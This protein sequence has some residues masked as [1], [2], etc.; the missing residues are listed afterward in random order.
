MIK[1][2]LLTISLISLFYAVESRLRCASG[3]CE[4]AFFGPATPPTCETFVDE[5]GEDQEQCF[6]LGSAAYAASLNRGNNNFSVSAELA[7]INFS[8]NCRC[9]ITLWS[10]ANFQGQS[11]TYWTKNKNDHVLTNE[12]WSQENQSFKVRCKF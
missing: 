11:F 9:A 3:P 2:I 6:A 5:N 1:T 12:I 8:G 7:E 4:I 10:E